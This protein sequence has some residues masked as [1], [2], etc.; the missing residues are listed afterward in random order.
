MKKKPFKL[1]AVS[2]V[3][4][5]GIVIAVAAL[6]SKSKP[7]EKL[8][9]PVKVAAVELNTANSESKYSATIIPRTEVQLAFNVGGYVDA[10]RQFRGVDGKMRDIQEGDRIS[11]GIVLARVRQSDYQ[12]KYKQAESQ[13]SEA[14][15]GIDV[16]K[17]QY[18]EAVS[19]IASSK[20]QLVEAEAAYLKAKLDFDR[21]EKL[22]ASH[23]MTKSDYDSAKAQYDVTSAKVAAARSQVQM[24]QAKADSA[25]ANIDVI[26]AKSRGAQAVVQETQIPLH[27]TELRSPLNGVVL[28]KSVEKGTL[29][30]SGDKAFIVADT[31]SVKAVF[32]VADVAVAEMKLGRTLSVESDTMPG[33]EFQGQITSVFPAA[34]SKSRAFNVEVTIA[35]PDYLLRP[36]MIVSLRV[37]T[38]QATTAQPVVPLNAVIK[39]RSQANGY[40]VMV[41]TEEGG[42]QRA[43]L[44]DV[45]LGESFGNAV[46]VAEGLR[47]GDRVI[48]TG[49]TM[50]NDGDQVKVIP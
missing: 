11:L 29:V 35:N 16:S 5:F 18:E 13:A 17:A 40:A 42:Q 15:S 3:L 24:V 49:G 39:S 36:N 31:S 34:D 21:A 41:V 47:P 30:S 8:P 44:R 43:R 32:G 2:T 46:A 26:Q 6:K 14:K 10:L 19:G 37:G 7:L 23:S 48:T 27:D 25:K 33:K 45:K 12:V 20:A 1:V 38:R 4:L 28:E 9:V 22:F 50:V